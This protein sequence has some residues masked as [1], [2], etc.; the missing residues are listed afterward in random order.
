MID[1]ATIRTGERTQTA[2]ARR[3]LRPANDNDPPEPPPAIGQRLP[4]IDWTAV[5]AYSPAA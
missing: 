2:L 1:L 3:R 5:E 4:R